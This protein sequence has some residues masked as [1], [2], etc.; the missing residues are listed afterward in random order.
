MNC[1]PV[2]SS[3]DPEQIAPWATSQRRLQA[4]ALV[5]TVCTVVCGFFGASGLLVQFHAVPAFISMS[6]SLAWSLTGIAGTKFLTAL[7]LLAAAH[8]RK[9]STQ[10]ENAPDRRPSILL[11]EELPKLV[12]E[13]AETPP[14][15]IERK[16]SEDLTKVKQMIET[17]KQLI[18]NINVTKPHLTE[19]KNKESLAKAKNVLAD[20]IIRV[21]LAGA[22]DKASTE[23]EMTISCI[24][25]L[26]SFI[27]QLEWREQWFHCI[28]DEKGEIHVD[29]N[30][31]CL[32]EAFAASIQLGGSSDSA[33]VKEKGLQA[34]QNA[35]QWIHDNYRIDRIL[36]FNLLKSMCEHYEKLTSRGESA[37]NDK[38]TILQA[39]Y[40]SVSSNVI[41]TI[42]GQIERLNEEEFNTWTLLP[43]DGLPFVEGY[44]E[45]VKQEGVFGGAAELYAL[46]ILFKT[47]VH[48]YFKLPNQPLDQS[49]EPTVINKQF[50]TQPMQLTYDGRHYN[51]LLPH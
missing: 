10:K 43:D 24:E 23:R 49:S 4:S 42:A 17:V 6:S 47:P 36:Q 40:V 28:S 2:N 12:K 37:H 34:R 27:A 31:N 46:S 9:K 20:P 35:T 11:S 1:F 14:P 21:F 39:A 48:I 29:D 19:S 5:L 22:P 51:S 7:I 3:S 13:P 44:L 26:S 41:D 33:T 15:K 16:E 38:Y 18:K 45:E 30:G 8:C 25:S 50:A 32:F